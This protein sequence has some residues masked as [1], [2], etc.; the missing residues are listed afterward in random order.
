M[1]PTTPD[2]QN[3]A[4]QLAKGSQLTFRVVVVALIR[5][6]RQL[7]RRMH[8]ILAQTPVAAAADAERRRLAE[9]DPDAVKRGIVVPPRELAGPPVAGALDEPVGPNAEA[10]PVVADVEVWRTSASPSASYV[11]SCSTDRPWS[12]PE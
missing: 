3:S 1:K 5:I 11:I 7:E 10:G 6:T 12:D 4:Y 8:R 9:I 2:Q